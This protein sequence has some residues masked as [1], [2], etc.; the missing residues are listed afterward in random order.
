MNYDL[1][2]ALKDIFTWSTD[3]EDDVK[4]EEKVPSPTTCLTNDER[5]KLDLYMNKYANLTKYIDSDYLATLILMARYDE[6]LDIARQL[7]I[8]IAKNLLKEENV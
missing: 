2:K 8:H 5:S 3:A 7:R 6:N 1:E 4:E